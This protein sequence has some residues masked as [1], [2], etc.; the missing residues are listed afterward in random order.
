MCVCV[1]ARLRLRVRACS[2]EAAKEAAHVSVCACVGM[3][4]YA[5]S[6]TCG[7]AC[8]RVYIIYACMI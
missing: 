6:R 3:S 5:G 4:A 7:R 8:V 1:C 2:R